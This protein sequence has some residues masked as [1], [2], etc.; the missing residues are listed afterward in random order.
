MKKVILT[1]L[2]AMAIG[3]MGCKKDDDKTTSFP[4]TIYAYYREATKPYLVVMK[5]HLKHLILQL[6]YTKVQMI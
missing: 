2:A 5:L 6:H 4:L 1:I 3:V